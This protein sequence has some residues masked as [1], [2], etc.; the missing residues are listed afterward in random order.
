MRIETLRRVACS[1]ALAS[2]VVG[3]VGAGRADGSG[4]VDALVLTGDPTGDGA[5]VIVDVPF[6]TVDVS[7]SGGVMPLIVEVGSDSRDGFFFADGGGFEEIVREGDLLCDGVKVVRN[8]L[9]PNRDYAPVSN[10]LGAFASWGVARLAADPNSTLDAIFYD[11]GAGV[12]L[13]S[14]EGDVALDG[15]GVLTSIRPAPLAMNAGGQVVYS[16]RYTGTAGGFDDEAALLRYDPVSGALVEVVREND[17]VPEGGGVFRTT[18]NGLFRPTTMNDAGLVAFVTDIDDSGL[19]G[20]IG[21]YVS[22]GA[23]VQQIARRNI[24]VDSG[25]LET[26]VAVPPSINNSGFVSFVGEVV[27]DTGGGRKPALFVAGTTEP[28]RLLTRGDVVGGLGVIQDFT[29][30]TDLNDLNQVAVLARNPDRSALLRATVGGVSAIITT[31]DPLPGGGVVESFREDGFA[32]NSRGDLAFVV[33]EAGSG[34]VGNRRGLFYFSDGGGVVEVAR[35]GRAFLGS[36]ITA[37]EF[38]GTSND[39]GAVHRSSSG[40][41]DDGRVAFGFRLADG[42]EG[43]CLW[44]PEPTVGGVLRLLEGVSAPGTDG[45]V[46]GDGVVDYFDA[47]LVLGGL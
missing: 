36:T 19:N 37:F 40:I 14:V 2:C 43:L 28:D 20:D 42:R 32:L 10:G 21:I 4:F 6:S 35:I 22:D 26:I 15:N 5:T 11:D 45:D 17:A 31:G 39:H 34:F 12:R 44:T 41:D 16:V 3:G 25:V 24:V 9:I 29:S 1:C 8:L 18:N 33:A 47:A 46:N 30:P 7:V 27:E 38:F 23:T 13:A